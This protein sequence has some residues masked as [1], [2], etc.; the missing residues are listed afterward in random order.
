MHNA[1]HTSATGMFAQQRQIDTIANN[2]AN[3]NTTAFKRTTL[4]FQDLLYQN[5]HETGASLYDGVDIPVQLQVGHGTSVVASNR[6]FAQGDLQETGNPLDL[7]IE[8]DGFFQVRMPDGTYGYTRDGSFKVSPEGTLV[9]SSGFVLEPE[10]V[11]PQDAQ[12]ISISAEGEVSAFVHGDDLPITIGEIVMAR[13][14][15]P[16][17]LNAQGRN[18]YSRT[19]ASGEPIVGLPNSDGIGAVRQGYV[20][21]SNVE[22]VQE[23]VNMIL[24]QRAYEISSK[25]IQ[26]SDEMLQL[27]NNLR[28]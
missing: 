16:N 20:E 21:A 23:M 9:T 18:L 17:G 28:R 11:I 10:I 6:S 8:G 1:L 15:N 12:S 13:F 4:E 24:A 5:L 25:A 14:I 27:A 3:V 22:V 26:T 7:V 19:P 2:L